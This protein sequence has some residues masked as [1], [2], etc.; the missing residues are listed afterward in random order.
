MRKVKGFTLIEMIVA[1][2]VL[3]VLA[4]IAVPRYLAVRDSAREAIK[5]SAVNTVRTAVTMLYAQKREYPTNA[6]IAVLL[7]IGESAEHKQAE[8]A[9][10][11]VKFPIGGEGNYSYIVK[12]FKDATCTK[13]QETA[14]I[15]DK[16]KCVSGVTETTPTV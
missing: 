16:V 2:V 6:E 7:T 8:A 4:S 15:D 5:I 12:T 9:S 14:L 11:G 10:N 3:G 1:I 13:G